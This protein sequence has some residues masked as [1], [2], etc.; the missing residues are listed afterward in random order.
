MPGGYHRGHRELLFLRKMHMEHRGAWSNMV[1]A[2]ATAQA[3]LLY[4]FQ[5]SEKQ[6][7]EGIKCIRILLGERP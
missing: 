2:G 1:E 6:M 5:S 4:W 3:A 7:P